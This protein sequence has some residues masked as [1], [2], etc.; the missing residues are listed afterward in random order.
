MKDF[1]TKAFDLSEMDAQIFSEAFEKSQF[2]KDL[3]LEFDCS[4]RTK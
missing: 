1:L 2:R 4:N 3:F